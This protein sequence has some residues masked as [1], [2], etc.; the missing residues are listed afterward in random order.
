MQATIQTGRFV[1]VLGQIFHRR[2]LTDI[3][4]GGDPG[5][6][7]GTGVARAHH[8]VERAL[9]DHLHR[10]LDLRILDHQEAPAL[11]VAAVGGAAP[12]SRILRISASGTGS[13]FNRRIE[14]VVCMISKTSV[15][16]DI[17]S[18]SFHLLSFTQAARTAA[19]L[20]QPSCLWKN[21]VTGSCEALPARVA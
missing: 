6:R 16:S 1:I 18:P 20:L 3:A 15:E 2:V 4:L 21:A 5:R 9:V 14:R 17:T 12:A 11:R 13:G 8:L 10:L 19:K 7:G